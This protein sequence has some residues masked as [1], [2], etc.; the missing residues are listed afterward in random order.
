MAHGSLAPGAAHDTGDAETPDLL[1]EPRYVLPEAYL[2]LKNDARYPVTL[3]FD[4]WLESSRALFRHFEVEFA[5]VLEAFRRTDELNAPAAQPQRYGHA[6]VFTESLGLSPAELR[7]LTVAD[8][9]AEWFRLYGYDDAPTALAELASARTLAN[10]LGVKYTELDLLVRTCFVNPALRGLA[11]LDKLDVEVQDVFRFRGHAAWAAEPLS[12]EDRQEYTDRLQALG[13]DAQNALEAAWTAGRLD[14]ILILRP[15]PGGCDFEKTLAKHADGTAAEPYDLLRLHI[16]VR[17]WRR[18]GFRIQELD[19]ALAAL[20]PGF[21]EQP[22]P[23]A[24]LG[25]ALATALVYVAHLETVRSS[26]RIR[27]RAR[28]HLL[29]LWTDLPTHGRRSLYHDLFLRGAADEVVAIFDDPVGNVPARRGDAIAL[30]LE[31]LQG[32]LGLGARDIERILEAHGTDAATATLTLANISLLHRHALL[33]RG[34]RLS[35]EGLVRLIEISGLDPFTPLDGA[36]LASIADDHPFGQTLR[37]IALAQ[38]L[39]GAGFAPAELDY[40]LRHRFDPVGEQAPDTREELA[41]VAAL[42]V[43]LR[44]VQSEYALPADPGSMEDDRLWQRIALALPAETVETFRAMWDGSIEY[45][46]AAAIGAPGDVIDAASFA[47]EERVRLGVDTVRNE[48]W[49]VYRGVLTQAE[50]NRLAGLDPSPLMAP[51]LDDV[52]GQAQTFFDTRLRQRPLTATT[53]A[54]FLD[55]PDFEG[56]LGDGAALDVKRRRLLEAFTPYLL[57][58]LSRREVVRALSTRFERD[59]ALVERLVT[60]AGLL[61]ERGGAGPLLAAFLGLAEP[62][63]TATYLDAASAELAR[64]LVPFVDPTGPPANTETARYAGYLE[65]PTTGAYRF[66]VRAAKAGTRV[67]LSIE[68]L[69]DPLIEAQAAAD[70]D[71]VSQFATLEAGVRLRF[72][73][74][75]SQLAGGTVGLRVQDQSSG[76]RE[77]D[78]LTLYPQAAMDGAT[79]SVSQLGKLFDVSDRL[80]LQGEE[81]V[82]LLAHPGDFGRVG[83]ERLPTRDGESVPADVPGLLETVEGLAHYVRLREEMAGGTRGLLEVLASARR[84]RPPAADAAAE[85]ASLLS[86]L[87]R[88]IAELTRREPAAVQAVAEHLGFAATTQADAAELRVEALD[89]A[90]PRSLRR[91]WQAMHLVSRVGIPA[92]AVIAAATP[93][94]DAATGGALRDAVRAR[95]DE[96]MWQRVAPEIFDPLRQ[97]R[98]DALVAFLLH[99]MRMERVE[100]LYEHFLIDPAMEP[101]V[102]TS[103][104]QLAIASVQLFIQRCLLNLEDEVDPSAINGGHWAWMKRYRVWEAARKLALFPENWLEPEFRDDKTHLFQQLEGTLLQSDVSE[105]AAEEAFFAYLRGLEEIAHLEIVSLHAEESLDPASTALHVLGRTARLPHKYFYRKYQHR[106]WTPWAPVE[107]EIEGDHVALAIWRKRLQ[108]FW[109]T[110]LDKGPEESQ[111]GTSGAST[112]TATQAT[113]GQ[114]EA[115]ALARAARKDVEVQL[116]WAEYAEG[117]W[118]TRESSGFGKGFTRTVDRDFDPGKVFIRVEKEIVGDRDQAVQIHLGYPISRAFRV[119][120]RNA[121]PRQRST[122]GAVLPPFNRSGLDASKMLGPSSGEL[123]VYFIEKV[124]RSGDDSPDITTANEEILAKTVG[125]GFSVVPCNNG[126]GFFDPASGGW[127]EELAA[128]FEAVFGQQLPEHFGLIWE[129]LA[130]LSAYFSAV[131]ARPFFYQNDAHVFYVEPTMRSTTVAGW[132]GWGYDVLE[133]VFEYEQPAWWEKVP[134]EPYYPRVDPISPVDPRDPGWV[135]PIPEEARYRVRPPRDWLASPGAAVRVGSSLLGATGR[136]EFE[137]AGAGARVV[138]LD[139]RTLEIARSGGGR[140]GGGLL[141]SPGRGLTSPVVVG[142]AGLTRTTLSRLTEAGDNLLAGRLSPAGRLTRRRP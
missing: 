130:E 112:K 92:A 45:R 100:Q 76:L 109:V 36:P 51:L 62:G 78:L 134:V 129:L 74:T 34:L 128:F 96:A 71:E 63:V 97:K 38:Q 81:L 22:L 80:E 123:E 135:D 111:P 21:G 91:L 95:F 133:P 28:E 61:Q 141:V 49:L 35:V 47:G 32:A 14:K 101:V 69:A 16:F 43:E 55:P 31:R 18:L 79:R 5:E 73:L 68:G 86:D 138:A 126:P 46:A 142:N 136:F 8:P 33:A 125:D 58:A 127:G 87:Y 53:S 64:R 40:L 67:T 106:M 83:L 39:T 20:V 41:F 60:D 104:I 70:G 23:A 116:N 119:V 54:G 121:P 114:I 118:S 124:E 19:E 77:L 122:W 117:E 102:Q 15:P 56:L 30:H 27:K 29:T 110:F 10:R 52:R 72:E 13:V 6:A 57:E 24:G 137:P 88:R 98:R 84:S 3:P 132:N 93:E 85:R 48:Q 89:F 65:V 59:E 108:I 120:N 12:Q 2:P 115:G 1:A 9:L 11:V 26:L 75:A 66:Y 17:L 25:A 82:H 7:I 44:R 99:R 94:P 131:S 105:D 107:V 113:L 90:R 37:F 4:L 140:A 103:R 139:D 42:A 50:R